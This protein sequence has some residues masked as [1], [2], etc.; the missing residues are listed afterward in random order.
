MA[1]PAPLAHRPEADTVSLEG[2]SIDPASPEPELEGWTNPQELLERFSD[3]QI[4]DAMKQ[5]PEEIRWTLLLID[6]EGMQHHDAAEV[7]SVPVGTIKSRVHRGRA[8]LRRSLLPI[9]EQNHPRCAND[10]R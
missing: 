6:V 10:R 5:L 4:I 3:Q 8:M 2:S 7:L 9:A 1:R